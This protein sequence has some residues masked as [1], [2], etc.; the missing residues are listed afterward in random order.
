M[1]DEALAAST[2]SGGGDVKSK[3]AAACDCVLADEA[4]EADEVAAFAPD[5]PE[6]PFNWSLVSPRAL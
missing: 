2:D 5:D 4:D 3:E 6:N 1:A